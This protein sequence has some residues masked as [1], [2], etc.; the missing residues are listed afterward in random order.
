[1][2]LVLAHRLGEHKRHL[3]FEPVLIGQD[4]CRTDILVHRARPHQLAM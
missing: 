1:M 2:T 3:Q 4:R